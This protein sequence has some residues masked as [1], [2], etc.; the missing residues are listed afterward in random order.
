MSKQNR[1]DL[2]IERMM[3][4]MWEDLTDPGMLKFGD[5]SITRVMSDADAIAETTRYIRESLG[6]Q[7]Y[8]WSRGQIVVHFII[9]ASVY[10]KSV[11][12]FYKHSKLDDYLRGHIGHWL[13]K[14]DFHEQN[15]AIAEQRIRK[16]LARI[17]QPM[18]IAGLSWA[19]CDSAEDVLEAIRNGSTTIA[20][21]L[22]ARFGKTIWAGAVARELDDVNL[23]V[24]TSYV[25]TV[26]TS[27]ENDIR[28][29]E[30]F[31]V[32]KH[33]DL[34]DPN[35]KNKVDK[36]LK[37]GEKV[38][39]YLGINPGSK[40]QE[41]IDYIFSKRANRLLIIDEAD[42][43]VH[44]A[45][46]AEPLI[47]ARKNNDLVIV[48]TGTN[49]DRAVS[50]W[51]IDYY[52]GTT[53]PELVINK[54]QAKT[55]N[56]SLKYFKHDI[57]RDKLVVD[58]QFYQMGLAGVADAADKS[59]FNA[60][61]LPSWSKFAAAPVLADGFFTRML[62]SVFLGKHNH[63]EAK[64]KRQTLD[65]SQ[66]VAMMFLPGNM[67]NDT[68][69]QAA[70]IAQ[71]ALP[72][73][74][75]IPLS[76]YNKTTNRNAESK[77]RD[78]IERADKNGNSVLFLASTIAQRSFSVPRIT[79]LFLA[80]DSGDQAATIQKMSRALTPGIAGKVGRI[81][82]L[83][84]DPN[85]DDKFDSAI[86][87]TAKNYQKSRDIKS[88]KDAMADVL[89]TID[90]FDCTGTGATSIDIDTYL[91]QL[92]ARKSISR[93]IGK[94]ANFNLLRPADIAAL[95]KGNGDYFKAARVEMAEKG[96]TRN[97][98]PQKKTGNKVEKVATDTQIKKARETVV[99]IVENM[100]I[101]ILGTNSKSLDD[102][103]AIIEKDSNMRKD[104]E[105]EFSVPF[106]VIAF[107]FES[108][109][110]NEGFV[111]LLFDA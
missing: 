98:V 6:R 66:M 11:G 61:E 27:F 58:V 43:G 75:V 110:I 101:I 19:Q 57:N 36:Y 76:G 34:A 108:G 69:E 31:R 26:F 48:M 2:H 42:Y 50:E 39:A 73:F 24:V 111:E 32:F 67:R 21:E 28:S 68:L 56:T 5:H 45:G 54:K 59:W 92:H 72:A 22:C 20:A 107:L 109:A 103:F 33:V 15:A 40:R 53:Y 55:H 84:F 91:E 99:A 100:D 65:A 14:G 29:F 90:I 7:K 71:Q 86:L 41:R 95:A 12:R 37:N 81:W 1:K 44:R 4:Y 106:D 102:A 77:A 46:Q 94:I 87:E 52:T 63:N 83:S 105:Q 10:A 23:V 93:V 9:D 47:K 38:F 78:A 80:Y 85:R 89:N 64:H 97:K 62:E 3:I 49:A 104:V 79:D 18:P 96:R 88:L 13:G 25:K 30:Q 51:P 16:E 70:E 82:S 17:N 35:Y 8:K 60:D 74:E